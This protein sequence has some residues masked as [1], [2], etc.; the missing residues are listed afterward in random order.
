MS[1]VNGAKSRETLREQTQT[2]GI[3][4]W[5]RNFPAA[6]ST[7]NQVLADQTAALGPTD[8]DTLSTIEAI[9]LNVPAWQKNSGYP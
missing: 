2:A 6:L 7:Y 5:Q 8:P 4:V 9:Q 1:S 3:Y